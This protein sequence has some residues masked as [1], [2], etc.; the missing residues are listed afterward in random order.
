MMNVN[1]VM[2]ALKKVGSEQSRKIYA[3]HGAPENMFGCKVADMKTIAKKIKGQQDL[4]LELY[5]TGNAD[6]MYLA[7]IVADGTRMKKADL[8]QWAR[9][10]NWYMVSE[11]A[12][13]GVAAEH[14]DAVAIA[15]KWIAAKKEHVAAAGWSTY[16][17]IVMTKDDS[18]LNL[19]EI[20]SHLKMIEA[21]IDKAKNRVRYTMNGFVIAVGGY[22]EPLIDV[23]K[24]TAKK[25]GKVEVEMGETSCKVPL[26]TDY[27]E[28]I[29]SMGR[30]GKKKKSTKC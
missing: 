7:G 15:N 23:A 3:R 27:I 20:K 19:K 26:A 8:N 12:V 2:S 28:K 24:A 21:S 10:A 1:E 9:E 6:A 11:Y 14:P 5:S 4:A 13:A 30:V 17:G 22:V 25:I 16:A 29:E 18:E